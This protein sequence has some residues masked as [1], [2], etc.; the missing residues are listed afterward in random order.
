M[1]RQNKYVATL[2]EVKDQAL[3]FILG[4]HCFR[5]QGCFVHVRKNIFENSL[6]K[7]TKVK[8]KS[9]KKLT[10]RRKLTRPG[11]NLQ[12]WS[13]YRIFGVIFFSWGSFVRVVF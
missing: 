6:P 11:E 12:M 8:L 3:I 7:E 5:S 13:T 2:V 1:E 10:A 4:K 9:K